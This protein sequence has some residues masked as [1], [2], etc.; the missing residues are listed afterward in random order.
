MVCD[1][2]DECKYTGNYEVEL[3]IGDKVIPMV[4]YVESVTENVVYGLVKSLDGFSEEA[5]I[6]ITLKR[7]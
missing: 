5:D 6:K 4:P 2:K 1:K 3:T 7:K